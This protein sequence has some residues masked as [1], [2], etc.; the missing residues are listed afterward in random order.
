[1]FL[2]TYVYLA[3]LV[4]HL[5]ITCNV[6]VTII[7]T[8]L[9]S[10]SIIKW[11]LTRYKCLFNV[12]E[13]RCQGAGR[14]GVLARKTLLLL[15]SHQ[16][17]QHT[18]VSEIIYPTYNLIPLFLALSWYRMCIQVFIFFSSLRFTLKSLDETV[19]YL[20]AFLNHITQNS[21]LKFF[22]R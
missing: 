3:L 13:E 20:T 17:V 21:I 9:F 7:W 16:K 18:F 15:A 12:N 2:F 4:L 10:F 1:M 19:K 11:N 8:L 6:E 22:A 5:N 14:A